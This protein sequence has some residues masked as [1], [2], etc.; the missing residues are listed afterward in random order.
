MLTTG[1][2]RKPLGRLS[3]V[4]AFTALV[5]GVIPLAAASPASRTGPVERIVD[6]MPLAPSAPPASAVIRPWSEAGGTGQS[7]T[8]SIV[9]VL[10][11]QHSGLLPGVDVAL[12]QD[13]TGATQSVSSDSSGAFAFHDLPPGD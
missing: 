10:Y 12:T 9:G 2:N 13:A 7:A 8:A 3:R 6:S 1:I 4:A 11:D 5:V